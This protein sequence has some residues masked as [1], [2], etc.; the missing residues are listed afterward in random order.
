VLNINGINLLDNSLL[1]SILKADDAINR[2]FHEVNQSTVPSG[3]WPTVE[4]W[5]NFRTGFA[6]TN[7][8]IMQQKW[9]F[10][11][12]TESVP[13]YATGPYGG[14]AFIGYETRHVGGIYIDSEINYIIQGHA[15]AKAGIS[16]TLSRSPQVIT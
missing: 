12:G 3:F 6:N 8:N 2:S 7:N 4:W 15:C 16:L 5:Y 11:E 13:I 10:Y 14:G 1:D 9:L